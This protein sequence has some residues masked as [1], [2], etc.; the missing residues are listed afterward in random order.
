[1]ECQTVTYK[2]HAIQQMFARRINELVVEEV[3]SSGEVIAN[4]ADDK[5]YPTVLIHKFVENQPFHVVVARDGN[6]NCYIITAYRPNT[7]LWEADF[8]TKRKL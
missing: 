4:Y 1:M 7:L 3:V 8:R 5:P 6:G 2:F